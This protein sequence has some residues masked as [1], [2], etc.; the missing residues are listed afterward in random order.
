MLHTKY[1][2]L[3]IKSCLMTPNHVLYA[4]HCGAGHFITVLLTQFHWTEVVKI[5]VKV[6]GDS[7][8]FT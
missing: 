4:A 7:T 3:R 6:A 8:Y 1:K 5:E 2:W